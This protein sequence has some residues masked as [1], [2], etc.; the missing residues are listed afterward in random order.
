LTLLTLQPVRADHRGKVPPCAKVWAISGAVKKAGL[1][2]E[3]SGTA[4][5]NCGAGAQAAKHSPKITAYFM[6][7][8]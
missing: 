3:D 7:A 2:T 4:K 8:P 5:P 6:P 1:A